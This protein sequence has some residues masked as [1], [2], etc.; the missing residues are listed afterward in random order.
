MMS[1][2][3]FSDTVTMWSACLRDLFEQAKHLPLVVEG[4]ERQ[5]QRHEIMDRVDVA[6]GL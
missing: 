1:R 4:G 3:E 6:G 2:F 5:A